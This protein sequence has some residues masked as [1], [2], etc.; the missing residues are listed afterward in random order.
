MGRTVNATLNRMNIH[1]LDN[2]RKKHEETRNASLGDALSRDPEGA[3]QLLSECQLLRDQAERAG[4]G[5]DDTHE[6]LAALDQLL[7]RWHEDPEVTP[8]LGSDAGLYLGTV[9]VRTVPDAQWRLRA[10]GQP[11]VRR[12]SGRELDVLTEG[13]SWAETGTPELSQLYAEFAEG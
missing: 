7:P 3:A 5:L 1:F 13:A 6:S 12:G 4:V 9:L 11:V 8:W 10:D 2:W